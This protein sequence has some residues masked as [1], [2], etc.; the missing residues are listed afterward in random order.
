MK[1]AFNPSTVA[2]L[3]TPPNNKDIT[4]DLRGRN[5]FA[6][7]V[8]FC[9]TDT[10]RD[11]KINN[12]SIGSNILDLRNGS[13]TTL[14]NTNGVV[15]INSTWRPVVDNLTSDSTTSSL[16]ANQGRVLKSLIDGKSN[17]GHT[18]DD[19]YL[20]LTG[21][22][23]QL[24][25]GLKFHADENYFGTNL[26]A[27]IIS[28]LDW[29]GKIC[30]GGLIIDERGVL[31]GKEYVTEL[32][33]IRDSEFKWKGSN[34][35]HSGN[36]YV[37]NNKGY[38]Y[39]NE[40]T[41]VN[42]A[43]TVDGVHVKWAGSITETN[44]LAAW[45]NSNT[46][47]C[48]APTNVTVGNADKV[49]GYHASS[50]VKFYLSPM[51]QDAPADSAKSWFVNTMPSA[52]GAIVYNVP[53]SEKTIIAGKSSSGAYG[54]MLQLN[55]D[56]TY[57]KI[58]RYKSNSW[59][60]TDWE[61]ISAGYADSS[62][63]ADT[64][65][66]LHVH[67]G[68]NNEANK[69]VRT[70]ANGYIQAGWI[71]TTSGDMGTTTATRIY[72]SN[73]AYI[74]YK[75][76][77]NFSSDIAGQLY[78]A[79]VKV[80]TSSNAAT[81]PTFG[82]ATIN[83]RLSIASSTL[84]KTNPTNQQL[85][86]NGPS[87]D[88][89]VTPG[90][91]DWPGIGFHMPGRTW[92]SLIFNG[93]ITAIS[94]DYNG[95]VNYYGAGFRKNGSSDSYVLLGGGGHKA[96]SDFM[97][98]TIKYALSDTIGGKALQAYK[99]YYSSYLKDQ[100]SIDNFHEAYIF[101]Y[102][103][104]QGNSEGMGSSYPGTYNG[105][106]LSG[107][108]TSAAYG[109][110]LAIDDDPNY[111][112]ALRQRG[113]GTW[114]TWKRIPM[115]DGIGAS[116]TWGINITGNADTVDGYHANGLLT[117]LSNSNNGISI[118]VG[119]TTKSISNISVNYASSAGNADTLD[120]LD[121]TKFLRQVV[122]PNNT[123]N[124]FNTFSNMTLTGRTD[125]TTGASLKNAPWS[126]S[127]PA[128]GY[129]VLTYLF[130]GGGYGTQMAWEYG[131]NRIYIRNKHWGGSEVG[132][133]WRTSWDTL[134]LTSDIPSSLKNPYA[135]TISLNG[136]SQGPYDGSTAKNINITPSS[137]GAATSGHTH[138]GR[139]LRWNGS[140]ADISAMGWGTLTAANG[141]TILSHA[142]S[143]DGGD[144]GF[145]NKGGQI[146]MQLDGYYY[147]REGRHRVLDTSDFT[148]FSNVGSQ[149]TRITIGEVTK[150]LKIDADTIDGIHATRGNN[151]PWGTI[152][153]ITTSGWMDVGKQFE[154]HYD[155][156]G[157]DYS[158][159]LICT[160]N[161]SNVVN[162]PSASGTLA[163]TSQLPTKASWNYDDRYLKLSGGTIKDHLYIDSTSSENIYPAL[164]LYSS[165]NVAGSQ[166]LNKGIGIRMGH[167][168]DNYYAQIACVFDSQNPDYLRPGLAFY[169]MDSCYQ[170]NTEI[171]RMR[172]KANGNVGIGTSSPSYKLHVAGDIFT[173]TGF[174]KNGS[175][176]SYVL[177][178]GGGHKLISD[179]ATSGHN[180]DNR[181]A[182]SK[183]I[184]YN[185]NSGGF[186]QTTPFWFKFCT[187]PGRGN[188]G[189]FYTLIIEATNGS[190]APQVTTIDLARSYNNDSPVRGWNLVQKTSQF[191]YNGQ[192]CVAQIT[193][194]SSNNI[195]FYYDSTW[196]QNQRLKVTIQSTVSNITIL[197]QD[198]AKS[199]ITTTAPS[200]VYG[201]NIIIKKVST[202]IYSNRGII[203]VPILY[204]NGVR[205]SVNGHTH[206]DRYYTESEINT[207]LSAYLPL[208]GGTMTGTIRFNNLIDT[209]SAI[210][211]DY[212]Y[213]AGGFARHIVSM[214]NSAYEDAKLGSL[215]ILCYPNSTSNGFQY[216]YLGTD[217]Y[218]GP[219][220]LRI[221]KD[222]VTFGG[223]IYAAHFY[224]SSDK[225]LK[226]NIKSILSSTN[227]PKI[228]EFDW[229]DTGEHSYGFIAQELE[230]QGY[231]CLV[232]ESDGKKTVN[233]TATL[234]LTVAKL[235]NLI[236]IQNKKIS[237]LTKELKALKYGRK[238]NS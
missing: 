137:I 223:S 104:W 188:G 199:T 179:F 232:N 120:G 220:N 17:S 45:E 6:R 48:I 170:N 162:L 51:A 25:E 9:G 16:S 105:I 136:T 50:L 44:W 184:Y 191:Y 135:L 209:D 71:N 95:Y 138:D 30:D 154:F 72:C 145:V 34:I 117:A 182:Y 108:W 112:I 3:I 27:R 43:D 81:S 134:A 175:S 206:D 165:S 163:L 148:T 142:A 22:T 194:D 58:L 107:G 13:N 102:G 52:S 156:T 229:K 53:G 201:G 62:G 133:V 181:Y 208:A 54:H 87:L 143:S 238:K 237:N 77:A 19:R 173:T 177:L 152:P 26:D 110:Q 97:S 59:K 84:T 207:K 192:G 214:K 172:I 90:L 106:I 76:L 131:N 198:Q 185:T 115:G 178:G 130:S 116:G 200:A 94:S 88:S 28:L 36:T 146:F 147:Q 168:Y 99:L 80:S 127:G 139:Y 235:Q 132:A 203:D 124:D 221:Y 204:E 86:I 18:H 174:K 123:E 66:G 122:V 111:F 65:D 225:T 212:K 118:T 5:I 231:G 167:G 4:F 82:S 29:N 217:K 197:T 42:N 73:D 40:I 195:W 93:N 149:T 224:E 60:S 12:V 183:V 8:K 113:N 55:Y 32:L 21:G 228:R 11:I 70:D 226:K 219:N 91:K 119:G 7:G 100:A 157:S 74:R 35:L 64:V 10:W 67:S 180:H 69:I 38:I 218:D 150:D 169:T 234:A 159:A 31:D 126:G 210:V 79:N 101:K 222:K 186:E 33:R 153:A 128:G 215:G 98:S 196:K 24:G 61:K 109:F 144:M 114:S 129:G 151:K 2:A 89:S 166:Q 171:E 15:T 160:G 14:T 103:L 57:L 63:N 205:V 1:I 216:I 47:R 141:Y 211:L 202:A 233:Y 37:N 46:I 23:M 213:S 96:L 158:T 49:D 189:E 39:G 164:C 227:I 190:D 75:T 68:R 20:K 230:E 41:E 83:T 121:S 85:V 56:N 176:D 236:N 161:H 140:T 125:P 92:G 193:I 78:W 187:L 155:N